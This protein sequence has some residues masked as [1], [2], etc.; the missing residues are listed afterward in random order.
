MDTAS[1]LVGLT[2]DDLT[3][4]G[5]DASSERTPEYPSARSFR[6]V[7]IIDA[8]GNPLGEFDEIVGDTLIEEKSALGVGQLHPRTGQ[9]VQT[10][11]QWAEKQIFQKTV[12]RLHNLQRAA[13]TRPTAG[14]S[15]RVPTLSDIQRMH[16]LQ[17]RIAATTPEMRNAVQAQL[18]RLQT[19]FPAWEF[20]V[21]FGP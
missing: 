3:N 9:P 6:G 20:S 4:D 14:G 7:E 16:K 2:V 13:A 1:K 15:S 18:T 12:V 10:V 19:R 17:F 21:I 8:R 5:S 11:V